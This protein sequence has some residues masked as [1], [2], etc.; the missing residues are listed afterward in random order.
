MEM[1]LLDADNKFIGILPDNFEFTAKKNCTPAK[2]AFYKGPKHL[3]S[4][5][6]DT[7]RSVAKYD[8]LRVKLDSGINFYYLAT[9]V[10]EPMRNVE[11]M[12]IVWRSLR[13]IVGRIRHERKARDQLS[14]WDQQIYEVLFNEKQQPISRRDTGLLV[15]RDL[16]QFVDRVQVFGDKRA[17]IKR[18]TEPISPTI[19]LDK[20]KKG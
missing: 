4:T 14:T 20:N 5:D 7:P 15:Q 8:T 9:K 12:L 16:E 18:S 10:R 2:V 17:Q 19:P 6:F 3:F 11:Q 1:R 13:E